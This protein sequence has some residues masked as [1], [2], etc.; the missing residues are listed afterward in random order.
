MS[1]LTLNSN[2]V[3]IEACQG[4]ATFQDAGR[5]GHAHLAISRSGAFDRQSHAL[6]N[7]LVGNNDQAATIELLRG[8]MELSFA[9]ATVIAIT[10]A[11]V[12]I[13]MGSTA[14]SMN[15]PIMVAPRTTVVVRTVNLAMR[16][17]VSVRGGYDATSVMG[18]RSYDELSKLGPS[19]IK[20]GD[21]Y[22]LSDAG[23]FDVPHMSIAH[24]G[25]S[26]S[27]EVTL[28]VHKGPRWDWIHDAHKLVTT[29]FLVTSE[30]NRVGVRLSGHAFDWPTHERL[31][32]EAIA[33]GSIQVPVSGVP[34]IFG[35]DHP[36]TAGYPVI[37]VVDQADL[38][39]VA[40][41][42]PGTSV[43]FRMAS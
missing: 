9:A 25:V 30:V 35:P 24:P 2:A 16:T 42:A 40:Q 10:G 38:D 4:L 33:H 18:S 15:E 1:R 32:S 29:P 21:V 7:R 5:P 39:V 43:R 17:Y 6:A 22:G 8:I 27:D 11:P 28:K 13:R 41:V 37:A 3:T 34:L 14:I 31:A 12:D 19:P 36:T 23:A 20:S 26:I